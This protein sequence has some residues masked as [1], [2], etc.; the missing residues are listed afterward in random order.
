VRSVPVL[1]AAIIGAAAMI[2]G[3][4]QQHGVAAGSPEATP[5]AAAALSGG[6][7][8]AVCHGGGSAVGGRS[9]TVTSVD[10]GQSFCVPRGAAVAVYLKGTAARKWAP[11]HTSS[12]VLTPS[13]N[14]ALTLALGVTG[15]SFTAAQPGTAVITSSRPL[16]DPGVPPGDGATGTGKIMCGANLAFRVTVTV[17]R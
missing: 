15:A 11:I 8:G 5:P 7:P 10:N 16:C 6:S 1:A 3:C 9:L 14:G 13:A 17:L 12:A 2:S 4:G